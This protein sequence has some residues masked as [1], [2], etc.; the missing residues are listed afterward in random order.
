M[1]FDI[2]K[3]MA[4][5]MPILGEMR[6]GA[7]PIKII[8]RFIDK[9]VQ[10]SFAGMIR[11][12]ANSFEKGEGVEQIA[13]MMVPVPLAHDGLPVIDEAGNQV[14]ELRLRAHQLLN[15]NGK[16]VIGKKVDDITLDDLFVIMENNF[17][18]AMQNNS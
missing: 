9:P 5:V 8:H 1:K 14:Y 16:P 17:D 2:A 11:N 7:N 18:K 4:Q 6:K 13:Y 12:R 15:E 10:Y 3:V